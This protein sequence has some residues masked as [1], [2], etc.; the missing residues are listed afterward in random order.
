MKYPTLTANPASREMVDTF[1]G[2]DHNLRIGEG[3]FFDMK[4][5]TSDHY[6]I[7]SP[8]G[9]RG[10]Y[11]K[12]ENPQG[13]IGKDALCYVDGAEFVMGEY[14]V[15][16]GLSTQAVDCPK[17]LVSMGA[18]VI[19]L[20]DKKY[21]NTADIMEY[22][23]I[24]AEVTTQAEVTFTLCRADGTSYGEQYSQATEP[25]DPSNMTLWVDTSTTPNSLKQWSESSGTW[26]SIATTYVK[27]QSAGIGRGFDQ[28][29]GIEITG[30]KG[31]ILH[32]NT[33]GEE[34]EDTT[35]LAALEGSAIIWDKADDYIVVAG[36]L[37]RVRSITDP[38]TISRKMPVMD[39]VIESK[40]RLWG[41][42]YGLNS[43]GEFVNEL[44]ASKLGSFKNWSCYMSVSTDSYAVSM[45]TDG[46][47]T[48]AVTYQGMPVFFKEN[49]LHK[50]YGDYPSNFQVQ[51]TACSGVQQGCHRSLAIVNNVLYYLA[52][53][54]V[55]AYDGSLPVEVSSAFG[56]ARYSGGVAAAC[57]DKYYIS[58]CGPDGAWNVFVYDTAK[59]MW[60]REDA[61]RAEAFCACKDELYCIDYDSKQI[62]TML[63]GGGEWEEKV[64]WMVQTGELGLSSP[65]MKYISRLVLRLCLSKGSSLTV[66][67]QY[68]MEEDWHPL[69][70]IHGTDLRSFSLP[71]RPRRCDFLRLR[72][73]GRGEAKI[74]SITK[75]IEQ[76]SDRS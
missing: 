38:V 75:T 3:E 31:M 4:N 72:M 1:L 46:P 27:I 7:L 12:P 15:D 50:V 13:M 60:H 62:I 51:D 70:T 53:K 5:M 25:T 73:E 58:M 67:A 66:Y 9:K 33:T 41:C 10:V 55:C 30:L 21:I 42:R 17:T 8:R 43:K 6:P 69:F 40:N 28:Y 68:D 20:P 37:D 11:A 35:Q 71:V 18:Y 64:D 16:L 36:I 61:L 29:D 65:D 54:G 45:G 32:D 26:I 44:Y 24:E 52:R 76:G 63:G 74:Y 49:C 47:F 48:G 57:G 19:I 22:G 59:E 2:Y 56:G 14:R 39:Y 23:S 34:I